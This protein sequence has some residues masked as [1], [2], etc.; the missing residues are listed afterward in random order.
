LAG[1]SGVQ[2]NGHGRHFG[3]AVEFLDGSVFCAIYGSRK[4]A[5]CSLVWLF[6][7]ADDSHQGYRAS[8]GAGSATRSAFRWPVEP[9]TQAD[10]LATGCDR[11]SFVRSLVLVHTAYASEHLAA[12]RTR[13]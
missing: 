9:D 10:I 2:R 11:G 7:R 6:V 3:R 5:G 8:A 13:L 1:D 4:M 12:A